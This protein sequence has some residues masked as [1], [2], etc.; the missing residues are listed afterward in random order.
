MKTLR[1]TLAML[2]VLALLLADGGIAALAENVLILPKALQVIEEEAFYGD[3]SLDKV[4]LPDNVKEIGARAF[5]NSTLSEINL[6]DSLTYIA[7]SA[8]IGTNDVSVSADPGTYAY[9]WAVEE[10]YIQELPPTPAEYF[11][12]LRLDDNTLEITGYT[13]VDTDVV[14]PTQINGK[15]VTSIGYRAFYSCK[16][17]TSIYIPAS[18]ASIGDYAFY[19]CESLT[20]IDIPASVTSIGKF[21]FGF[22]SSLTSVSIPSDSKLISIG[23]DA[24]S[25]A[26]CHCFRC[27]SDTCRPASHQVVHDSSL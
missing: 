26:H 25:V 27:Y 6:P 7:D 15:R 13:G 21:A 8:F 12:T 18:V 10:G 5:A 23:E 2:M 24:F 20:S 11:T 22:C 3:T 9:D 1:K 4:V 17:L 19:G 16:N 14:I